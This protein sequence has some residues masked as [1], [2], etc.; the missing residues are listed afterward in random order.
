MA[1]NLSGSELTKPGREYRISIFLKKYE[2]G[3]DFELVSPVKGTKK[4]KLIYD[5]KIAS[6]IE[7]KQSLATIKFQ[8]N[9]GQE[10]KLSHLAKTKE[11]GGQAD[12]PKSTTHIEEAEIESIRKQ[13]S[14]IRKKT[15]ESTVPIKIKNTVYQVADIQKTPGTPKSDFHFLDIDGK[16][17]V[18]MS[19]KDGSK[20][21]DF[22]QWGGVSKTV[23]NVHRHKETQQFLSQIKE[24]FPE[25]LSPKTNIVKDIKDNI[26]KA[27]SVYGDDYRVSSRNYGQDNVTLV[28]QG[29]VKLK[30]VGQYYVIDA[31]H[32]HTNG[33][34]MGAGYDPVFNAN[35][36]QGR[37]QPVANARA[38]VWPEAGAVR[39][40]SVKLPE[41]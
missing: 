35:Y 40:N 28:L 31:N 19:H 29:P 24:N 8:T 5:K 32:V 39:K 6:Q 10:I 21:T 26:I 15:K 12:S 36:R 2:Q 3:E 4:V 33:Q 9:V 7:K 1:A 41:K 14:D 20:P 13:L 34:K 16:E 25:G 38:G 11:F 37:G 30:K 27:K 17:I 22:Q 18:W 23:P